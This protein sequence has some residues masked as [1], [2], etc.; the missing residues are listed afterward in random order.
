VLAR[1]LRLQR[2]LALA[3]WA[4]DNLARLAAEAGYADHAHLASETVALTGLTPR[5]LLD[6]RFAQAAEAPA[7]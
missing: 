7:A 4:G 5:A 1:V 3:P 6:D 2:M